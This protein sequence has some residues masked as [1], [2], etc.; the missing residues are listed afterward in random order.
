MKLLNVSRDHKYLYIHTDEGDRKQSLSWRGVDQLEKKC[1]SLIG[2][3]IRHSTSGTWDK[4]IWFQDVT[5][6]NPET[7]EINSPTFT[8]SQFPLKKIWNNKSSKRIYG[9]PGTGKTTR[10]VN[11]AI[12]AIRDGIRPEDIGYFAFTN[13]AADE[14]KDRIAKELDL[15]PSRFTNFSTLHSLT[16]R[17]GGNEGKKLCQKE[18]LQLFDSNI[19]IREEW[20][21]AGDP[22]SVVVRPDHPVLSEYSIMFN[23][24]HQSPSFSDRTIEDAQHSLSRYFKQPIPSSEIETYAAKYF[25]DYENFKQFNNLSDFNDVVFTVASD[26]FPSEKIPT[27]E[28]LII[29]EAQDLSALQ[30]DVVAK[31]SDKAKTTIIAGDDDQAIMESFGAAPQ[32]FNEFPTTE[33]DEVL[34][35]SFRL[36]RNIKQ[37]I[38]KNITPRLQGRVNRKHKEW[39]ENEHASHH[40]EVVFSVTNPEITESP[41]K[42]TPLTL[43]QF[44]RIV[45][46]QKQDE[47]LIMAPTKSTCEKIS[48]GLSSLK[49][50]HFCHRKDVI[51]PN[52]KIHV[53]TIHTSKG[54]GA[55]NSALVSISRGDRYL[56]EQDDRILYV[57]LTRAKK[58]LYL[59]HR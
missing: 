21:R 26:S 19:G 5:L 36:P 29:D 54:M 41:A 12:A 3:E 49:V 52:N 18:H 46:S 13:V 31:L 40:G 33:P 59:V 37:Y 27:F 42:S 7:N 32:L 47:W 14:A 48:R 53:Q 44:L 39:S 51:S 2:K 58:N 56:L 30:W 28:L 45:E 57:A 10:L 8:Q 20:L 25:E 50:P 4:E 15:E 22:S 9:P 17:M 16:T 35:I 23:R 1:Q 55:N 24:K 43:N 11:I 34:P 38:D 6:V